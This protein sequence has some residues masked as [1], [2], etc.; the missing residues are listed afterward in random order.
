MPHFFV[1]RSVEVEGTMGWSMLKALAKLM[2]Q[3]HRS[4]ST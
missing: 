1:L 4:V 2:A 3:L